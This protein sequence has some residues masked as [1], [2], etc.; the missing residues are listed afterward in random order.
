MMGLKKIHKHPK[1]LLLIT[2]LMIVWITM[3]MGLFNH[4]IYT[5]SI[6]QS[7]S[8]VSKMPD[9]LPIAVTKNSSLKYY[10]YDNLTSFP[11][12]EYFANC[13]IQNIV[14][15]WAK[16]SPEHFFYQQLQFNEDLV[17]QHRVYDCFTAD[18]FVIPVS[19]GNAGRGQCGNGSDAQ[20]EAVLSNLTK[21]IFDANSKSC[22]NINE[23]S[24]KYHLIMNGGYRGRDHLRDQWGQLIIGDNNNIW[25]CKRKCLRTAAQKRCLISYGFSSVVSYVVLNSN[26]PK[27]ITLQI[28]NPK[29]H[30]VDYKWMNGYHTNTLPSFYYTNDI[31]FSER[32]FETFFMGQASEKMFSG[33]YNDRAYAMKQAKSLRHTK[34]YNMNNTNIW[35]Q[36][37]SAVMRKHVLY[38]K[39]AFHVNSDPLQNDAP[40]PCYLDTS[41]E[42]LYINLLSN[43][44]FN[45]M[46]HGG[47]PCSSRFYDAISLDVINVVISDNFRRTCLI[48]STKND[49]GINS[50]IPWDKMFLQIETQDFRRHPIFSIY[51]TIRRY[52][53]SYYESM[54]RT[55]AKYKKYI[56]WDRKDSL[57]ALHLM[58]SAVT[59]C[60][61][62]W[63]DQTVEFDN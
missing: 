55:I 23:R 3:L 46:F 32:K 29:N 39:C 1:L 44:K 24:R 53:D 37:P 38:D 11:S 36:T 48:G 19:L 2:G 25:L 59:K 57:S 50:H 56:L 47:D 60:S 12:L 15:G 62:H 26:V 21:E 13:K 35:I 41:D 7:D 51:K 10:Y 42:G 40:Y 20:F 45:L 43:S 34:K 17:Q 27:H 4:V 31:Q 16:N 22:W 14:N 30:N 49:E 28:T 8:G 63:S 18:I 5:Q 6:I 9:L 61:Q 33:I 58:R 52:N 54:L